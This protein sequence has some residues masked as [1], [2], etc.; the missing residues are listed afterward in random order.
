MPSSLSIR[1]RMER[2]MNEENTKF[3]ENKYIVL[4][5]TMLQSS[6]DAYLTEDVK[7]DEYDFACNMMELSLAY[8]KIKNGK[9]ER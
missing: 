4:A 3:I 1:R 7:Q 6:V 8:L 9:N 5:Q 2:R